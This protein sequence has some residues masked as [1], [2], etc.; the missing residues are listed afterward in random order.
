[1]LIALALILVQ[2]SALYALGRVPFC[3]CGSIKAW[4]S[5]V[6]SSENSQH[7]FDWYTP[8]HVAHGFIFYLALRFLFPKTPMMLRLAIAV[9]IE[10]AWEIFENTPWI[11]ERYRSGTISL[12]YYGDSILNSLA[13]TLSMIAGFLL[14]SALPVVASVAIVIGFELFTLYWI[15]DNLTLNVVMLLYPLD[16]IRDWQAALP[17]R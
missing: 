2:A 5:T 15:R 12:S 4:Q 16:A 17:N 6:N 9:G 13:D 11:I 14:A 7:I 3:T 8:S 1:M 10:A